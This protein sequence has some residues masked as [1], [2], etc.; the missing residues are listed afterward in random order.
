MSSGVNVSAHRELCVSKQMQSS[1]NLALLEYQRIMAV[2]TRDSNGA[3]ANMFKLKGAQEFMDVFLKLAEAP[4]I[5]T[6]DEEPPRNLIHTL[7]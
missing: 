6:K 5:R 1:I 2:D 7:Q 3:A 4:V